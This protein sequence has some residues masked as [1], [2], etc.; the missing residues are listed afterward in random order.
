MSL[1]H[2][3]TASTLVLWEPSH[4]E[5]SWGG[6]WFELCHG[7]QEEPCCLKY[8]YMYHDHLRTLE[9]V[10]GH[11]AACK[12][13]CPLGALSWEDLMGRTMV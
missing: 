2:M 11:D 1:A 6:Q 8:M 7:D 10:T 3:L 9:H 13:P 5:M 4:G 12:H